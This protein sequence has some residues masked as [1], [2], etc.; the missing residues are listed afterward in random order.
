LVKKRIHIQ[1][2]D[3]LDALGRIGEEVISPKK[4]IYLIETI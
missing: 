4:R 3:N 1:V 2:G